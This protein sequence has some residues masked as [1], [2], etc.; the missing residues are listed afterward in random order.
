M[1]GDQR[2]G[3]VE[4]DDLAGLEHRDPVAQPLRLFHEVRDEYDGGSRVTD[5]AHQVPR[6]VPGRRVKAGGHFVEEDQLRVVGQCQR[7]EQA[8]TLATRQ[9]GKVRVALLLQPPLVD[10]LARVTGAGHERGEPVQRLHT[11]TRCGSAD[12][13][14]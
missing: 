13:C 9:I 11:L 5:R 2:T 10:Q 12:S 6:G 4:C 14:T 3:G 7:D 8:L 1:P